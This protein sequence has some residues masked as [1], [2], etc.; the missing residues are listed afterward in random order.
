MSDIA[1]NRN[2]RKGNEKRRKG[3]CIALLGKKTLSESLRRVLSQS[4]VLSSSSFSVVSDL[5]LT[6]AL[7]R[8][9][10]AS[11]AYPTAG[12][13]LTALTVFDDPE[14]S[15]KVVQ[16]AF[17][18]GRR[19]KAIRMTRR[20]TK[21][22]GEGVT[23]VTPHRGLPCLVSGYQSSVLADLLSAQSLDIFHTNQSIPLILILSSHFFVVSTPFSSLSIVLTIPFTPERKVIKEPDLGS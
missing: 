11:E 13:F 22:R 10:T 19:Q 20:Q 23:Y 1:E 9:S 18:L 17:L 5:R 2:E 4:P 6:N 16:N 21:P 15:F 3:A 12:N 8:L 7:D 14:A